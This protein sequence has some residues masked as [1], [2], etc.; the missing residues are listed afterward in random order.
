MYLSCVCKS[1]GGE[2]GQETEVGSGHKK[3]TDPECLQQLP[4]LEHLL[5]AR[6]RA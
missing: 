4:F 2:K 5:C 1:H 3:F 6:Y